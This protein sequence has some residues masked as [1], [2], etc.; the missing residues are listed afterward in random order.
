MNGKPAQPPR[1]HHY[2]PAFYLRR[3]S[4]ADGHLEQFSRPGEQEVKA[5]RVPPTATGFAEDLYAM[6]GMSHDLVQQIE[7]KFMSEVDQQAADVLADLES[8]GPRRW[9]PTTRS[10]WTRFIQSLELRTPADVAGLKERTFL[11]WARTVPKIQSTWE[12][13]RDPGDPATFEEFVSQRDPLL[14]E[15][16]A[17]KVM[18][19]LIDGG[20]TGVHINNMKWS[21]LD[22]TP[23]NL[24]LV[25]SDRAVERVWPLGRPAAFIT[26]PIGPKRLFVAA[27]QESTIRRLGSHKPREVVRLR[28][29]TT[30]RLAREFVW[31]R[32]RS[33]ASFIRSTFGAARDVPTLG[34]RLAA[35]GREE[36]EAG[37][38]TL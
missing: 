18:A 16:F 34:E 26:L 15:R 33:Q 4:G 22:L 10:A 23:S 19:V 11:E 29:G 27:N 6:P 24:D 3:W 28:N 35:Q 31:A 7:V 9:T 14:V 13:A 30:I 38:P 17:L 2:A 20:R 21:V 37:R 32:D 12:A 36:I 1:R 25:T 8:G 5:R